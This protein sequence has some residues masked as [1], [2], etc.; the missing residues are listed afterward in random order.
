MA[1][2]FMFR[3]KAVLRPWASRLQAGFLLWSSRGTTTGSALRIH[4][5]NMGYVWELAM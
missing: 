1:F 3:G 5:S 4:L 2:V